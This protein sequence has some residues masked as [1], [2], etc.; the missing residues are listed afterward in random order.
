MKY[1]VFIAIVFAALFYSKTSFCTKEDY[2][3]YS[4][5]ILIFYS[6]STLIIKGHKL[7]INLV[8][9]LLLALLIDSIFVNYIN[10]TI[11]LENT[12]FII[13]F[14]GFI[15]YFYLR[16]RSDSEFCQF[17]LIVLSL[18][19]SFQIFL[20]FYQFAIAL[21]VKN[22]KGTFVNSAYDAQFVVL[23]LP[24]FFYLIN[25]Y[26]NTSWKKIAV[27]VLIVIIALIIIYI[28]KSRTS[29]ISM[30]VMAFIQFKIKLNKKTV[31]IVS[32]SAIILFSFLICFKYAS[33]T[34]RV[35]ILKVALCN[36][37][38]YF[39]FGIGISKFS[40]RYPIWQATYF[41]QNPLS[42]YILNADDIPLPFNGLMQFL[43]ENGL[44]WFILFSILIITTLM[45]KRNKSD[46]PL[47]EMLIILIIQATTSNIFQVNIYI[48]ILFTLIALLNSAHIPNS[49]FKFSGSIP[50]RIN[51]I[52]TF[53]EGGILIFLI[54]VCSHQLF[55]HFRWKNTNERSS[56]KDYE[57]LYPDLKKNQFFLYEFAIKASEVEDCKKSISLLCEMKHYSN[58]YNLYILLGLNYMSLKNY[59]DAA[60]EFQFI[61]NYIPYKLYP[62]YLLMVNSKLSG[63][64][65]KM[66]FYANYLLNM[67]PKINSSFA[68][69]LKDEAKKILEH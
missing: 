44:L 37:K 66:K 29:I 69:Q 1:I 48:I 40:I 11:Y 68:G 31:L 8:D 59:D 27:K 2:L 25:K 60:K 51:R 63:D 17:F 52:A 10:Y 9:I 67:H 32:L 62:K 13:A 53:M 24:A 14:S 19:A 35:L 33:T 16:E 28:T 45:N 34:G 49:N 58:S 61:S 39:P 4:L 3:W 15:L 12:E 7:R 5:P 46:L 26:L 22:V 56:L 54:I 18:I 30:L 47:K 20:S 21:N 41:Y 57:S 36:L 42:K 65:A 6:L 23:S 38:E 43:I 50:S 64:S 55:I